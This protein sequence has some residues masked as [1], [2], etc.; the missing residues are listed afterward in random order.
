MN[1]IWSSQL[2]DELH[3][4]AV[5][6]FRK[7][8]VFAN[9]INRIFGADLVDM[10]AFSKSNRGFRYLLNVVDI[11]SKYGWMLPLKDK[12]G[13]SVADALKEIFTHRKPQKLWVAKGRE[14]NNKMS[15]SCVLNFTLLRTKRN[16]TL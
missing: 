9:G 6:I 2:A 1:M 7:R 3:K 12:T 11:F 14:V 15:K 10:Q 16:Q 13:K 8:K 4:P 5:K